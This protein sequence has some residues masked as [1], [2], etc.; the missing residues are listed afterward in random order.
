MVH[1]LVTFGGYWFHTCRYI[2]LWIC[3]CSNL[4]GVSRVLEECVYL[5]YTI[6]VYSQTAFVDCNIHWN[7][8]CHSPYLLFFHRNCIALSSH[9]HTSVM[10]P[11]WTLHR[12]ITILHYSRILSDHDGSRDIIPVNEIML[13]VLVKW[14]NA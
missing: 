4:H 14:N 2:A 5:W 13:S 12:L 6:R 11:R 8:K 3:R 9:E 10:Y 7:T 1:D